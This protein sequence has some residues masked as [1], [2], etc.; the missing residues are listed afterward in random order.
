MTDEELDT[1]AQEWLTANFSPYV[2]FDDHVRMAYAAGF[3]AATPKK[4]DPQT[5]PLPSWI[6]R[7]A[8]VHWCEDRKDRKKPITKRG[9][10]MQI[11]QLNAYM[12]D[13]H[14]P[15][16]V[17]G[18]SIAGGYQGLFAP[19][20]SVSKEPAWRT[21]QRARTQIAAPGVAVGIAPAQDFFEVEAVE[22]KRLK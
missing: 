4:F 21:E 16:D 3:K 6:P 11:N 20:A 1:A 19:K 7:A 17:I 2:S 22:L 13:G 12:R 14:A 5:I 9:A 15:A 8:W 18:Y 10:A